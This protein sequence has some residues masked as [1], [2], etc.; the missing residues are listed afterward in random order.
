MAPAHWDLEIKVQEKVVAFCCLP[1]PLTSQYTYSIA[2]FA[3]V[4]VAIAI[5]H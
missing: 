4:A 2:A 3:A 1:P 5:S